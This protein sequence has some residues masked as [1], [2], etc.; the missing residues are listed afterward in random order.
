VD[1]FK[2]WPLQAP[3]SPTCNRSLAGR[4]VSLEDLDNRISRASG[5]APL[6]GA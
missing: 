5:S 3:L 4:Q 1:T 6:H 2:P